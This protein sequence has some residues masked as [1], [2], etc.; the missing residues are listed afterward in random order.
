M[1]ALFVGSSE[2]SFETAPHGS[3]IVGW[4]LLPAAV[5]SKPEESPKQ[6]A[7]EGAVVDP[8]IYRLGQIYLEG[9][10]D[11][12]DREERWQAI[13]MDLGGLVTFFD[14]MV[15]HDQLPAFNYTDT[16]D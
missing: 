6:A 16:F 15:L 2:D 10:K 1:R 14:L 9:G 4:S 8:C 13:K 11:R 12:P 5:Q 7:A 3:P